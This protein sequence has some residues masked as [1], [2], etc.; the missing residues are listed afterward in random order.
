LE[1]IVDNADLTPRYRL[2]ERIEQLE[3]DIVKFECAIDE[4]VE[5]VEMRFKAMAS[6]NLKKLDRP[7]SV[8][9]VRKAGKK[10]RFMSPE[11]REKIAQS[12]RE[13]WARRKAKNN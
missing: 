5:A 8:K 6:K 3:R 10:K 13:R 4:A 2:V 1:V 7:E 9:A 11:A 12:Q